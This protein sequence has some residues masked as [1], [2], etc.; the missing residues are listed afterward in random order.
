MLRLVLRFALGGFF[1]WSGVVKLGDLTSFVDTVGNYQIVDRPWDAIF[2]YFVPW[3]EIVVGLAIMSGV[4]LKGGLLCLMGMLLGFSVAIAWV[5]S[6]GL[7]INCG[8]YGTS[9]EPTNY[10]LHL[11][12]NFL[13][14]CTAAGLF[15][16]SL[17]GPARSPA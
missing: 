11:F 15:W 3:F 9:D 16:T 6:E 17:R 1:L 10:P 14:F 12:Y 2:G 5:W 4:G 13:F 8:C 7:N